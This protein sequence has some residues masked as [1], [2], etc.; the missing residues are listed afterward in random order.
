ML[1]TTTTTIIIIIIIIIVIM[2]LIS[3][4]TFGIEQQPINYANFPHI[5]F[6]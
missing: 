6:A 1:T 3:K 2:I 5:M 4:H